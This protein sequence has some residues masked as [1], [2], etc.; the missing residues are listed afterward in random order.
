MITGF[1][2]AF[3]LALF[4]FG[5]TVNGNGL[6]V[7]AI[8]FASIGIFWGRADVAQPLPPGLLGL[9]ASIAIVVLLSQRSAGSPRRLPP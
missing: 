5:Y 6:R 3:S 7:A 2:P 9:G 8:I 1:L 4:V